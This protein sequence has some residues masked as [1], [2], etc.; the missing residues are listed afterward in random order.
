[1]E[2]HTKSAEV[3]QWVCEEVGTRHLWK[4]GIR[5]STLA[6]QQVD[7]GSVRTAVAM[8]GGAAIAIDLAS[9]D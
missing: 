1:M 5:T 8:D 9:L 4:P 2:G 7:S 6:S 3:R